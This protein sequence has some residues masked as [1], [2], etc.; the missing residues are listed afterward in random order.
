[1]HGRKG[2]LYSFALAVPRGGRLIASSE[3]GRVGLLGCA[4]GGQKGFLAF[5]TT[6]K[7]DTVVR[8][9]RDGGGCS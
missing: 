2:G 9:K 8:Q 4:L 6:A 5:S 1:M 7:H 3:P